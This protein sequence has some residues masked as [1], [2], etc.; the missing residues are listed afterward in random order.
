M[1]TRN[2]LRRWRTND[3][4]AGAMG[5]P[6]CNRTRMLSNSPAGAPADAWVLLAAISATERD[7]HFFR[8]REAFNYTRPIFSHAEANP[9]C[10]G[11]KFNSLRC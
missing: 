10:L 1:P 3:Q 9:A 5:E 4:F 7:E 11:L 2:K 6:S 8:S